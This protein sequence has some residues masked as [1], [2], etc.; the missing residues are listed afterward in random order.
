MGHPV[1]S[2]LSPRSVLLGDEV[3]ALVDVEGGVVARVVAGAR[4]VIGAVD[5]E[6]VDEEDGGA[7]AVVDALS[8]SAVVC[9]AWF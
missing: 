2:L 3:S 1:A 7:E 4:D 9:G 5:S 8:V 6:V